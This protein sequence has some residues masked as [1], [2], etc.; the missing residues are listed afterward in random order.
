MGSRESKNLRQS[1]AKFFVTQAVSRVWATVVLHGNV[2]VC[3]L[4]QGTR[5]GLA[6]ADGGIDAAGV[7]APRR[8]PSVI[9]TKN[10]RDSLF[11]LCHV[12]I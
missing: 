2:R 1:R 11:D 8:S 7:M 6:D 10:P 4:W 12:V 3:G 5:P 9:H